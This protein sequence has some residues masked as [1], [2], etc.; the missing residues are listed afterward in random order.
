VNLHSQ[1]EQ[2]GNRYEIESLVGEGG[3]QQVYAARDLMLHRRVALKV[4]KT[5]AAERRFKRSATLSAKINHANAAKTLDY[6]DAVPRPYLIEEFI[7]GQDLHRLRSHLP[8]M[9]PYLVAHFMHHVARGVAASHHVGVVHR[10]L[11]PSNIMVAPGLAFDV[12]KVTDF[13]IAKMAEE[14]MAVA[15]EG[16]DESITGSQTMMGALPYLSPEMIKSPRTTGTATDVWAIGAICYE[17][18]TGNKPFGSGLSAVPNILAGTYPQP[19]PN[20]R[21]PQF[22]GIVDE[23]MGLVQA[24][25]CVSVDARVSADDL[26][27]SCGMLCYPS[28]LRTSGV[29]DSIHHG[30]WGFIDGDAGSVFFHLDSV[31]G[32]SV[33]EGDSVCFARFPGDPS[34]RAHP[35][36]KLIA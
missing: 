3:M 23:I 1:G 28:S 22:A 13:G 10:D 17:L 30:S 31:Y 14:E 20:I 24:C 16:G 33:S 19:S 9:D 35:V 26:V 32:S 27:R 8:L 7:E 29:I 4:P 34:P 25:L 11:K 15:A 36:V 12:I 5:T 2:I 6:I 18:L 21:R